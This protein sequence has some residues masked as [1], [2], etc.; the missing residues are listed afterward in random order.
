YVLALLYM[1]LD[2]FKHINDTFGH[3]VGDLVLIEVSKR[4]T[5]C[6]RSSDTVARMGGDE[7]IGICARIAAPGDAA[8][9][10][11]KI[12][13]VLAMPFRIKGLELAM[14]VSIGSSIYP[15]DGDDAETLVNK[16]DAAMY[17]IKQSGK[18]GFRFFSDPDLFP[19]P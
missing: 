15:L 18:G 7:F 13:A 2:N 3:E 16:A 8:V 11:S 5:S 10:A 12:I 9:V 17:K 19:A 4:M 14:G 6:T 1:D